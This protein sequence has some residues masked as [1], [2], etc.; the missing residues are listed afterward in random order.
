MCGGREVAKCVVCL[1]GGKMC[2]GLERWKNV[3]WT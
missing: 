2:G 1:R 3:W